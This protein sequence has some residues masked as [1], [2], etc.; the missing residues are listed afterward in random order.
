MKSKRYALPYII[1]ALLFIIG[2]ILITLFYAFGQQEFTLAYII[3][4]FSG[5]YMS[6]FLSSVLTA[7]IVTVLCLLL[8]YPAAYIV[9][10]MR[11]NYARIIIILMVLPMWINFLLRTYAWRVLL[12]DNGL[13]NQ[14]LGLLGI[15]PQQLL[16][17]Q[18]AVIMGLMYDFL[19]FMI[20]PIYTALQKIDPALLEASSDLGASRT[21]TFAQVIFPLSLPGIVTGIVMVFMPALTTFVVTVL[22]G[23]GKYNMYGDIITE[24]FLVTNDWN[25]GSALAVV[26]F[27]LMLVS[28]VIIRRIDKD[29]EGYLL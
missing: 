15:P 11:A 25:F 24:Q 19:P 21:R 18:G 22:L 9:S 7:L 28:M 17:T 20:L 14:F 3:K 26:M 5:D 13:I 10:R 6:V 8:G 27:L 4:A 29:G 12:D 16:Y 23:G 1:W 2:P